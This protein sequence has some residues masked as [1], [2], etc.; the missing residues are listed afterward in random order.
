M[1]GKHHRTASKSRQMGPNE[2]YGNIFSLIRLP[3]P[4]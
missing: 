1:A 3:L 2:G 4:L